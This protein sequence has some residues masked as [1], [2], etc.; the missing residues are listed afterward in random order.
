LKPGTSV[1]S[2]LA[3]A[4]DKSKLCLYEN[5]EKDQYAKMTLARFTLEWLTEGKDGLKR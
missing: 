2:V 3:A 5:G 1:Y 4:P